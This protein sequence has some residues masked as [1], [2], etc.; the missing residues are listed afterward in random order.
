HFLNPYTGWIA[1]REELPNGAGSSGVVLFTSDGGITWR[2]VSKAPLPGLNCV[3]FL[4]GKHGMAVGDA[5]A[6]YPSGVFRS[7]D[8]GESWTPLSGNQATTWLA[9]DFQ[10]VRTGVM[11]GAWGKLGLLSQSGLM[12]ADME[13]IPGARGIRAVQVFGKKALAVGEGG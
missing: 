11:V 9:A 3:H 7:I 12:R 13:E 8:G 6:Q 5:T 1:G 4:D 10:D 2:T